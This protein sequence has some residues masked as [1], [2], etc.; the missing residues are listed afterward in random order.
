[1]CSLYLTDSK[2]EINKSKATHIEK[3]VQHTIL[4]EIIW[5]KQIL[6][7]KDC[8]E[9][10]LTFLLSCKKHC[11]VG[12]EKNVTHLY[13]GISLWD[14]RSCEI[15]CYCSPLAA[16]AEAKEHETPFGIYV[17]MC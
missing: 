4:L 3:T 15:L 9:F 12:G 6:S 11:Q 2:T 14:P 17:S 8:M 10:L 7:Q 13:V 1:M 16:A 5:E